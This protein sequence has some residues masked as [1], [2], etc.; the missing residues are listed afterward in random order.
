ML[1]DADTPS[2][3]SKLKWAAQL[4]QPFIDGLSIPVYHSADKQF[5]CRVEF[6]IWHQGSQCRYAMID[7]DTRE[8]V[9]IDQ[10]IPACEAI[11][12]CM[13]PLLHRINQTQVLKSKLFGV[14]FLC[15]QQGELLV[16][17][18]YHRPLQ[19]S[20]Q[21]AAEVLE[22]CLDQ[23]ASVHIIGRSRKQKVVISTDW[24]IEHYKV[25]GH[26]F[27]YQLAENTFVQSNPGVN[28]DMLRWAYAQTQPENSYSQEDD[29]LELYCGNGNF[30]LPLSLNYR[31]VL[32]TE[33]DR[34]SIRALQ[35]AIENNGIANL[36]NAPLSALETVQ[37]LTF[38]R[39][40]RRL[41]HIDLNSYQL[42]TLFV[43]PPR[44]GLDV[45]TLEF[46]RNFQRIL[47]LSCN[48]VTLS[49]NLATLSDSHKVVQ[50]AWFDQFP[51]TR[52]LEAGVLLDR[53]HS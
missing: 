27:R 23:E 22:N 47:Y 29:L 5:R 21:Q 52:H 17:L 13:P 19:A 3:G 2:L 42:R 41:A 49:K 32:A 20:W 38:E 15:N 25:G 43:N 31:K 44:A 33:I 37:A 30:T 50:G 9:F 35:W 14:E 10:F 51:Y 53:I 7:P 26:S 46:A 48:P 8:P 18:L 45:A 34:T 1:K 12:S 40:F 39:P 16:T 28:G 24:I 36:A 11:N 6:R 4:L